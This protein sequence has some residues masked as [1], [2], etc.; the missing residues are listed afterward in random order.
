MFT[1][2]FRKVGD[3]SLPPFSGTRVM[4]LPIIIGDRSSIP[5][6]VSHYAWTAWRLAH[7]ANPSHLDEVGYLTID[8]K[9]VPT[10]LT[11]RR[12]GLHVDGGKDK[13]WGGGGGWSSK[14]SG[15]LCVSSPSGCRV[16]A[17]DFEGEVGEENDCEHLRHQLRDEGTILGAG[18]VYWIGGLCVHESLPQD[19]SVKRQFVRLSLPSTAPWYE[20]YTENPLG[21]L[22]TGPILPRRKFMDEV[23]A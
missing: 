19:T 9:L 23:A 20:G 13:G 4:M 1:S 11:H 15:M 5:D 17:Q 7:M 16:W 14:E 2:S 18:E 22:P 3:V 10:G 12:A 21:I 8:E 6:F